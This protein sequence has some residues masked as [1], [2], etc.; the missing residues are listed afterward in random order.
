MKKFLDE[1]NSQVKALNIFDEDSD[2]TNDDC[3]L[4]LHRV[5]GGVMGRATRV[6]EAALEVSV[7]RGA[8]RIETWDVSEAINTWAIPGGFCK[9]NPL[10]GA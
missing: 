6:L 9:S 2:F 4:A 7:R 10:M 1:L 3:V 5:S 8:T